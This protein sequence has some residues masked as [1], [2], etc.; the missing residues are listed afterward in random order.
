MAHGLCLLVPSRGTIDGAAGELA[1]LR[2]GLVV[3]LVHPPVTFAPL[4]NGRRG[5]PIAVHDICQDR[6]HGSEVILNQ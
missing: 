4:G 3:H 5:V 2:R 1:A 6:D